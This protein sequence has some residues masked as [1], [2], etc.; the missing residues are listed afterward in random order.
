MSSSL[1]E[2]RPNVVGREVKKGRLYEDQGARKRRG[3][4]AVTHG[5]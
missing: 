2:E 5:A 4:V 3:L 1:I